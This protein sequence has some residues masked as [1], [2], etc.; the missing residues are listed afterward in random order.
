MHRLF[1]ALSPG[2][3]MRARIHAAANALPMGDGRRTAAEKLH[4]TLAFLGDASPAPAIEAG[5]RAAAS[6]VAFDFALDEI[7][8][9][10]GGTWILRAPAE[11]FAPLVSALLRELHANGLR[12][13]DEARA[14]I[15]HVTVRRRASTRLARTPI[16]AVAWPARQLRLYDSDLSSGAYQLLGEWPLGMAKPAG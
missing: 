15:P 3:A 11:P 14:F 1:F 8:S 9:F 7:D 12:A 6:S 2:A 5:A 16:E 10:P 4:L 13:H